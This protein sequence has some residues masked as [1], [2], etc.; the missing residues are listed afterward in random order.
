MSQG[1]MFSELFLSDLVKLQ[2]KVPE[3][4]LPHYF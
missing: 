4:M 2:L 3:D 1:M